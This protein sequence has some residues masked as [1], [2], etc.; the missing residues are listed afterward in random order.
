MSNSKT[1]REFLEEVAAVLNIRL[2]ECQQS[3]DYEDEP[4]IREME[5]TANNSNCLCM[6]N[7]EGVSFGSIARVHERPDF[8]GFKF[9]DGTV[10]GMPV[11]YSVPGQTSHGYYASYEDLKTDQALEHHAT[12]VLMRRPK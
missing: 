3:S 9:K 7:D 12:H 2:P 10:M 4:E 1:E 11:K 6:Y 5:I 8:I